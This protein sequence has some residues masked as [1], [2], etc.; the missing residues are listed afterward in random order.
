MKN[1]NECPKDIDLETIFKNILWE[2]DKAISFS[3]SFL[4]FL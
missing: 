1:V 4:Y 2:H 3:D